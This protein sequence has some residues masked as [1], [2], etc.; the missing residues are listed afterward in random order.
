PDGPGL[1]RVHRRARSAH[2]RRETRQ[3]AQM[4]ERLQVLGRVE[5]LDRNAVGRVP[6]EAVGRGAPQL[7]RHERRPVVEGLLREISHRPRTSR[8][9]PVYCA[10]EG[11]LKGKALAR[12][13]PLAG[14]LVITFII[15]PFSPHGAVRGSRKY[16]NALRELAK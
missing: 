10:C 8:F 2:E 15:L 4:V 5:G 16:R 3:A 6:D 1:V 9:S 13:G 11:R 12:E 14:L 7:L